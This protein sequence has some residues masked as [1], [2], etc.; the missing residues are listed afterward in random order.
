MKKKLIFA[1][2]AMMLGAAMTGCGSS[3]TT[4]TTAASEAETTADE[5]ETSE[6]SAEES[7]AEAGSEAA[8]ETTAAAQLANPWTESDRDG[9][10]EATG[11]EMDAPEGATDVFYSYM[12][13]GKLA[14]MTYTLNGEEWTYRMQMTSEFTDLSGMNYEWTSVEDG[15]VSGRTA[16]YYYYGTGDLNNTEVNDVEVV[17]WYDIVPGIMYSLSVTGPDLNGLDIQV[18][19]ENMFVP[20]QGEA[21]DDPERDRRN[22]LDDYFL[23]KHTSSY[24]GSTL[25]ITENEDGTFGVVI[26]IFRLCSLDDGVG[27]FDDHKMYF[28]ATDPAEGKLSGVIYRD[29]DNTLTIKIT[30]STWDYLHND[31]TIGDFVKD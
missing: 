18:V 7:T 2:T 5:T 11:F 26:D 3:T 9:V 6:T 17:N 21:T 20:L 19:A 30:D 22:E 24:D 27:T 31:E 10:I 1:M 28:T 4:E 29:N 14:Q 8:E 16:K 15:T 13:E 23:G 25:E 12:E